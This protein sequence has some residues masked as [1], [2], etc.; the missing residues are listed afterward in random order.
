MAGMLHA[1]GL[2][3]LMTEFKTELQ[4]VATNSQVS[5]ISIIEAQEQLLGVTHAE[6]GAFLLS[7][8]GFGD[9]VVEAV[10]DHHRPSRVPKPVV[11]GLTAVHMAYALLADSAH[12]A[13]EQDVSALDMDY[14]NALGLSSQLPYLKRICMAMA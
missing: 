7:Q 1:V 10:A 2:V 4:Q 3:I 6:L 13:G 14:V 11:N 5:G 8:W 9:N 12:E